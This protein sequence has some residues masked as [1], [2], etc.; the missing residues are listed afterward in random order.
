MATTKTVK[1]GSIDQEVKPGELIS[2]TIRKA[3]NGGCTID[4]NHAPKPSKGNSGMGCYPYQEHRPDAFGSME[5]AC[6]AV[7]TAFGVKAEMVE[8]DDEAAE[9][10]AKK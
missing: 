2:A 8:Y 3:G 6:H 1:T 10:K 5:E 4:W 7:A 9:D